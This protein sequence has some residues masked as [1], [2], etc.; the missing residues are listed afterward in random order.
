MTEG[1]EKRKWKKRQTDQRKDKR[2]KW[3]KEGWMDERKDR[4]EVKRERKK[5]KR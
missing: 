2:R 3:H 4:T 1:G 5:E